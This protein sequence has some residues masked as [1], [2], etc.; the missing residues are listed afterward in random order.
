MCGGKPR[1]LD[2]GGGGGGGGGGAE[3]LKAPPAEPKEKVKHSGTKVPP[4]LHNG[5]SSFG[6]HGDSPG[7]EGGEERGPGGA[8]GGL[9]RSFSYLEMKVATKNFNSKNLVGEGGFGPVFHGFVDDHGKRLDVA[10]KRLNQA[11]I[12]GNKEWLAEVCYLGQLQHPNVVRLIGYCAENEHKMLVYQYMSRGS[13]DFALFSGKM[14]QPLSWSLRL[15]LALEAAK[16]LAFLHEEA[17]P[18]VIYRDFKTSN[19]LLDTDW[20]A[21]LSDFGL[22]TD[23]PV[24]DKSHVSTRVMGTVGYAAPDYMLT[25]HLTSKSD[26]YSFGVVLLEILTGLQAVDTRRPRNEQNLVDW[27]APLLNDRKK[28]HQLVDRALE[29]QYSVRG[30]QKAAALAGHCIN[31][32]PKSRP[33]MS[34][35][36]ATLQPLQDLTDYAKPIMPPVQGQ[37]SSS[38]RRA[39]H[40]GGLANG[41][42]QRTPSRVVQ[43]VS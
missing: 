7:G 25:G 38:D 14:P 32:D 37:I 31:R 16:G 24:G 28:V 4:P 36:V 42:L 29:G 26:V 12:Q 27:V 1:T 41:S 9:L 15:K 23:G 18:P 43:R 34:D 33:L 10:V 19:I 8:G 30:L 2:D 39:Q 3:P 40:A 6:Q 21:K 13:L 35:V 5:E 11:G 22:A 17:D 20:T